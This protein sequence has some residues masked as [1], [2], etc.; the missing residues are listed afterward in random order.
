MKNKYERKRSTLKKGEYV[1]TSLNVC[2]IC[3]LDKIEIFLLF[4]VSVDHLDLFN[5]DLIASPFVLNHV[6]GR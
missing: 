5:V 2:R 3:H 4:F 1:D 6:G